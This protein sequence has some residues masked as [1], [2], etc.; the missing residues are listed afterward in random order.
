MRRADVQAQTLNYCWAPGQLL[1][2]THCSSL[3]SSP[4]SEANI[5]LWFPVRADLKKSDDTVVC[6][7]FGNSGG[8]SLQR[9]QSRG[10][11][12]APSVARPLF[13]VFLILMFV[14]LK[15]LTTILLQIHEKV[16][17]VVSLF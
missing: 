2:Q 14:S 8:R 5:P 9:R 7:T 16:T 17:D 15:N 6:L 3:L 10:S 13:R 12:S 4:L 1:L 11:H